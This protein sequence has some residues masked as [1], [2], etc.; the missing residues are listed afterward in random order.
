MSEP[1]PRSRL[2]ELRQKALGYIHVQGADKPKG[3]VL[4]A[5]LRSYLDTTDQEYKS[6]YIVLHNEGLAQTD[7]RNAHIRLTNLGRKE[8]A[9]LEAADIGDT[10]RHV[11]IGRIERTVFISY[12]RATAQWAALA[13]FQNLTQHDYDVFIDYEGIASGDFER[14]ILE[15][16]NARA[17]FLVLLTPTALERCSDPVD[18]M[19]REIEAAMDSRRNIVPVTLDGF[20]FGAPAIVVSHAKVYN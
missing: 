12:R 2:F 4:V 17:H 9:S 5:D 14:I 19:R 18:W 8:A 10:I 7:G 15:N 20:D 16:I 1:V 13:I 11:T 3:Y 6:L